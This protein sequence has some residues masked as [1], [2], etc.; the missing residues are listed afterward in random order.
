MKLKYRS[1]DGRVS[2][3]HG[4]CRDMVAV[5]LDS[6][7]VTDPPYNIGSPQRIMDTRNGKD[8]L[9]GSDFGEAFDNTAL[10]PKEWIPF[11]PDTVVAFYSAKGLWRLARAFERLGYEIVQDFHWCKLTP[12]PAMRSVGFAWGTESGFVFRREGT[13]HPVNKQAGYSPNYLVHIADR[14]IENPTQ[15]PVVV[16]KW[17]IRYLTRPDTIVYDPFMGSGSTMVAAVKLGRECIG[18]E[19]REDYC[20]IAVRRVRSAENSPSFKLY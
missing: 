16:M 10:S 12:P 5:P 13:K 15:K 17:L 11:M 18:C 3:W 20:D 8:R 9:I 6:V 4:D 19:L 7:A 14:D 1:K 2:L